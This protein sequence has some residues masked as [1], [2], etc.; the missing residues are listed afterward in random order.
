MAT[1]EGDLHAYDKRHLFTLA[2]E[3]RTYRPGTERVEVMWRGWKIPSFKCVTTCASPPLHATTARNRTTLPCTSPIGLNLAATHGARCC[4]HAPL[5]TNVSWWGSTDQAPTPTAT[6]T[7]ATAWSW[8]MPDTCSPMRGEKVALRCCGPRRLQHHAEA[9]VLERR[10][11]VWVRRFSA[12]SFPSPVPWQ[13]HPQ[14]CPTP[15]PFA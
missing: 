14:A 12:G 15:S 2:G 3:H 1:P 8:T 7:P 11:P 4:K 6:V 9:A 10:G 5:R 13:A